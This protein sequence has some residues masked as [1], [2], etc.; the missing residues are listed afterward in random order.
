MQNAYCV[1]VI[2]KPM[3]GTF[4]KED[5]EYAENSPLVS[6]YTGRSFG[7]YSQQIG[8]PNNAQDLSSLYG[9]TLNKIHFTFNYLTCLDLR[10]L[11][12]LQVS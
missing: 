2:M 10:K 11:S 12:N 4:G 9:C 5:I 8:L 3:S 7:P 6:A 1:F